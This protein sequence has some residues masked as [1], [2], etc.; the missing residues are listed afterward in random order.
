MQKIGES[1]IGIDLCGILSR[2]YKSERLS[3]ERR[4]TTTTT[5]NVVVVVVMADATALLKFQKKQ[6]H[7][8]VQQQQQQQCL[9]PFFF[10]FFFFLLFRIGA[11]MRSLLSIP[12]S[13]CRIDCA[14]MMTTSLT[15]TFLFLSLSLSL[16]NICHLHIYTDRS[17]AERSL[18]RG[19][20]TRAREEKVGAV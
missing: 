17:A 14:T 4:T 6:L 13:S 1:R 3:D 11:T 7:G 20:R 10:V 15:K 8:Q 9:L 5:T 16:L 2:E 18:G 12:F 19:A